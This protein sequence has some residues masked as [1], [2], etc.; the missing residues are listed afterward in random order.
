MVTDNKMKPMTAFEWGHL[1]HEYRKNN[2]PT[3]PVRRLDLPIPHR[4]DQ[5]HT[6]AHRLAGLSEQLHMAARESTMTRREYTGIAQAAGLVYQLGLEFKRLKKDWERELLEI[7]GA[8]E[9]PAETGEQFRV[10]K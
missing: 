4:A 9:N 7:E 5:V 6:L 10:V 3:L 8:E 1:G 2:K